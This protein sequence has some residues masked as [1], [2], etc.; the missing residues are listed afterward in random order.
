MTAKSECPAPQH[1]KDTPEGWKRPNDT[2]AMIMIFECVGG[3]GESWRQTMDAHCLPI[4]WT[5]DGGEAFARHSCD[6]K[7]GDR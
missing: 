4:G 5:E 2:A 3:G 6:P 7:E 1:E